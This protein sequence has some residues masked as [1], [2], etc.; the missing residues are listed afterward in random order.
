V[1]G[2]RNKMLTV[3]GFGVVAG[4]GA[5]IGLLRLTMRE[6]P[7]GCVVILGSIF[8]LLLAAMIFSLG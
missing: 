5:I 4:I 8:C 1:F 2:R 3:F 7:T 6:E